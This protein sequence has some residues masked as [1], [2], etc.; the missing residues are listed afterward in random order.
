MLLFA[1]GGRVPGNFPSGLVSAQHIVIFSLLIHGSFLVAIPAIAQRLVDDT[2][3]PVHSAQILDPKSD[4]VTFTLHT[5]LKLPIGL[6]ARIEPFDI[7]LYE[8]HS[9]SHQPFLVAP[10]PEYKVKG[11]TDII[12]TRNATKILNQTEFTNTLQT[13]VQQ[14]RFVLSAK[15]STIGHLGALKTPLTLKKDVEL[16]GM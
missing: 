3:L 2:D 11:E 6:E 12:V 5:S 15:G 10:L 8:Y 16:D 14:K 1:R 4:R 7:G 13:A 9:P